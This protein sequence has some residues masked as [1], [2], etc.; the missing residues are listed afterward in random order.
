MWQENHIE[1]HTYLFIVEQRFL[2]Q[3]H[4][5]IL[6]S[7]YQQ[8]VI[9]SIEFFFFHIDSPVHTVLVQSVKLVGKRVR[10]KRGE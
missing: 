5:F 9:K 8:N 6:L 7:A 4:E 10:A 2:I 1:L 3:T